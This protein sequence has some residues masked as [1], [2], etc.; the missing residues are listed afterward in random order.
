MPHTATEF[1]KQY[2][3]KTVNRMRTGLDLNISEIGQ[4][5]GADR[6]TITRWSNHQ[7]KPSP[8]HRKRLELLN[9][10]MH[11]LSISFRNKETMFEWLHS[12]LPSLQGRTPLYAA[13]DN[14]LEEVVK[15]LG[16]LAAG[17]FR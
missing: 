3:E 9:Q 4:I 15:I 13:Q 2:A 12:P 8:S 6:R 14:E 10:F 17:A 16:T 5:V 1:V 7:C 11:L